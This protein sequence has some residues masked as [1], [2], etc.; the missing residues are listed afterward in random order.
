MQRCFKV[1]FF[2]NTVWNETIKE[3]EC[4]RKSWQMS[5]IEKVGMFLYSLALNAS[6]RE[7]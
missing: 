7:V 3:D 5:V 1:F 4:Y 6:N 2:R